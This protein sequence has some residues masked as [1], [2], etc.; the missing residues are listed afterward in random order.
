MK[1]IWFHFPKWT[2]NSASNFPPKKCK[3][4]D[5]KIIKWKHVQFAKSHENYGGHKCR[6]K[7]IL[8][9]LKN[10]CNLS[11]SPKESQRSS[12][13]KNHFTSHRRLRLDILVDLIFFSF[14]FFFLLSGVVIDLKE[15]PYLILNSLS[16]SFDWPNHVRWQTIYC[17]KQT[18]DLV[19]W[20]LKIG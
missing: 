15:F 8:G 9:V 4:L 7:K 1:W 17:K 2:Q 16:N 19:N 3:I 18:C 6:K 12:W 20:I 14:D 5:F 11:N 13:K 10:R